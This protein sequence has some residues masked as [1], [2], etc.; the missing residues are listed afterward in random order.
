MYMILLEMIRWDAYNKDYRKDSKGS[1]DMSHKNYPMP[2][3]RYRHFK[4]KLYQILT[5]G[6]HTETGEEM[7]VY[8]ALYGDYQVYIR[9]LDMFMEPID[10]EKYPDCVQTMRFELVYP[11]PETEE[12]DTPTDCPEEKRG[13]NPLLL[14]F[15]DADSYETK[16]K[17]FLE[18]RD[19][20][21]TVMLT[22]VAASLDI[23][24]G[25]GSLEE[26]YA[27]VQYALHT[28][29]KYERTQR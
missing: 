25:T 7:V 19:S 29:A 24:T 14:Q 28:L 17:I 10:G 9:P 2:G 27:S 3:Q 26:Q 15:L 20:I 23:S 13:V 6:V 8:Q 22:D 5:T 4:G 11:N 12:E 16:L 1:A 18:M 21:D